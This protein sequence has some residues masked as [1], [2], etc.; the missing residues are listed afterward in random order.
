MRIEPTEHT[1]AVGEVLLRLLREAVPGHAGRPEAP[2][3]GRPAPARTRRLVR[4]HPPPRS[5]RTF[6][7]VDSLPVCVSRFVEHLVCHRARVRPA[8]SSCFSS[9]ADQH[10]GASSLLLPDGTLAKGVCHHFVRTVR[11]SAP[12]PPSVHRWLCVILRWLLISVAYA[13]R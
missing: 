10:G 7:V 9:S 5:V 4:R 13:I 3:P 8:D 1:D 12:C 11:A 2:P 6:P